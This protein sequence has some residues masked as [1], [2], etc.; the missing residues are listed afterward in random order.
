MLEFSPDPRTQ[1]SFKTVGRFRS[2]RIFNRQT[3]TSLLIIE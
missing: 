3:I 2:G 1:M